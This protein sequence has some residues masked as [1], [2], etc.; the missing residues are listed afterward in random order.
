MSDMKNALDGINI[1]LDIT[2]EINS[3]L[4]DIATETIRS[5]IQ[6]EREV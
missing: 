4:E 5:K 2:E 3:D 6:R 1:R